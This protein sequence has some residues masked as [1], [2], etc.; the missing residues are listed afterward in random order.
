MIPSESPE[1]TAYT[2]PAAT[3]L[4]EPQSATEPV[5]TDPWVVRAVV[6]ALGLAVLA[7]VLVSAW[8][9]VTDHA[10]LP[11]TLTA[12]APTAIGALGALLAGTLVARA[13]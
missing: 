1:G 7:I 13:K 9:S 6:V 5:V 3:E 12:I 4:E 2:Y 10:P 8:L 11:D